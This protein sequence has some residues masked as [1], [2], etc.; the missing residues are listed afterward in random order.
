MSKIKE[1]TAKEFSGFAG[2]LIL[3]E[4]QVNTGQ[5][6]VQATLVENNPKGQNPNIL[7]LT[8]HP[9]TDHQPESFQRVS[10]SK[11]EKTQRQYQQVQI[12]DPEGNTLE[13]F[14]VQRQ[15]DG[16]HMVNQPRQAKIFRVDTVTIHILKTNPPILVIQALGTVGSTGWKNGKL[17]P[18]V[19]VKPPAD[20]IYEFDFVAEQPTGLTLPVL[21]P[22]TAE[23]QWQNFPPNL[24]GIK[25]YSSSNNSGGM[26]TDARELAIL[27]GGGGGAPH[28]FFST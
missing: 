11:N 25:V 4:G 14:Q 16:Q 3:V 15:P 9:A 12:V 23:G 21:L 6:D 13:T 2:F 19:Y 10:F 7:L 1:F 24:K 18:F 22:I 20:G 26:L 17:I 27:D 28:G 5:L 8:A